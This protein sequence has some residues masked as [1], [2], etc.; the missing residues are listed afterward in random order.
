MKLANLTIVIPVANESA[1]IDR[2]VSSALL[3]TDTVI[4]YCMGTDDT[5]EKARELG[6][7]VIRWPHKLSPFSDVQEAM[8]HA[9]DTCQTPWIMRIDA[10]EEVTP[11]LAEE[12][13]LLLQKE[14]CPLV[15][16]GVPR[17]QFF[18]KKF[19][20]W[21]D[22]GYDRLVRL[23]RPTKAR[24]KHAARTQVHEQLTV[25]GDVGYLT[26][27]L[28]HYSHPSWDVL[29]TKFQKYTDLESESLRISKLEAL[30]KAVVVPP[31]VT[32]RWIIYHHGYRDGIWGFVAGF[33]RGW[34]E[35]LTYTKYLAKSTR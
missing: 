31:Y 23:W 11:A 34:Y 21:G 3:V 17:A 10:D 16:Y 15:A 14:S 30:A 9:V 27:R 29:N 33:I 5:E 6:A 8:N 4:V 1:N 28:N 24:Y 35:W 12:I 32:A 19:L 20:Y 18:I 26:E 25:Q 13:S 7:H 2:C 22:W